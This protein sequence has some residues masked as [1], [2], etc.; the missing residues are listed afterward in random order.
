MWL[1]YQVTDSGICSDAYMANLASCVAHV[2]AV[3]MC[4]TRVSKT[5]V[6]HVWANMCYTRVSTHV[7][8]TCEHTRV[9]H[10]LNTCYTRVRFS[11]VLNTCEH[12]RVTH[13]WGFTR[14]THVWY[15]CYTRVFSHMLHTCAVLLSNT[16]V[17][18]HVLHTCGKVDSVVL[19]EFAF[20]N[21][22]SECSENLT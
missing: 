8:H 21:T 20:E 22:T 15:T 3:F 7:L 19:L 18:S 14:V 17:G 11:H 12:T 10:V 2:W 4:Y 16:R 1:Q 13:V 9:T 5:R 6:I